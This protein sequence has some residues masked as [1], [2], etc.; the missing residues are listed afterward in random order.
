[1]G[2]RKRE[3][4]NGKYPKHSFRLMAVL[5]TKL[6]WTEPLV[7]MTI[8]TLYKR[9]RRRLTFPFTSYTLFSYLFCLY[10]PFPQIYSRSGR[11]S[12]TNNGKENESQRLRQNIEDRNKSEIS[13]KKQQKH[14]SALHK[15]ILS[16]LNEMCW[17]LVPFGWWKWGRAEM[18][19]S[20]SQFESHETNPE[21]HNIV[22][23]ATFACFCIMQKFKF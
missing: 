8:I 22:D 1:M 13:A 20:I 10:G 12:Q 23:R 5:N 21:V 18:K 2:E 11:E 4:E 14:C 7:L 19:P 17:S 15:H 6:M 3:R 16:E 9:T